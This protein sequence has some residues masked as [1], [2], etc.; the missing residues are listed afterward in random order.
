MALDPQT[1]R[2]HGLE[3][4]LALARCRAHIQDAQR[5]TLGPMPVAAFM[6]TF[7]RTTST[8]RSDLLSPR[9]AFNAV[10]EHA[11]S[12]AEVY[13]PLVCPRRF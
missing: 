13:E 3:P 8:E 2:T 7:L 5:Y 6:E 11:D 10:P 9:N 1:S 12:A 4:V